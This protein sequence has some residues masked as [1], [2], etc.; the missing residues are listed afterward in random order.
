MLINKKN[1]FNKSEALGL[2]DDFGNFNISPTKSNPSGKINLSK[3]PALSTHRGG[4]KSVVNK[5]I[6]TV[7]NESGLPFYSFLEHPFQWFRHE[8]ETNKIIPFKKPWS[9]ILHNPHNIP[10]WYSLPNHLHED[11][12]FLQSLNA[13]K[14][15]FTM[16]EYHAK[17][18]RSKLPNTIK[19]ETILH[20]YDDE[21][22]KQFAFYKY[23]KN[24]Q[25]V[26]IGYWLRRQT[27]FFNLIAPKHTK[28]KLWP[29]KKNSFSYSF[30]LRKLY[31]ESERLSSP[32]RFNSLKH[33]H[34][35]NDK[36]YDDLL[37]TSIVFLDLFDTSANNA[38]LECIQRATP[39]LCSKCDAAVEYLGEDYPLFFN[40]L[41]QVPDLLNE[42]ILYNAHLYL[43]DIQKKETLTLDTYI[44]NLKSSLLYNIF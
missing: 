26:N 32:F 11:D 8:H 35:I 29:Y 43:I 15:L 20:P 25:I 41:S 23:R 40:G 18:L 34:Q 27:S 3:Q 16:S 4:W 38:I 39:I 14:G 44:K 2:N 37:S 21:E 30:V 36:K 19:I 28:I 17:F 12:L 22:V 13:C 33:L 31:L 5:M 9:G 7:H 6:D 42:E 24:K 10:D 1:F